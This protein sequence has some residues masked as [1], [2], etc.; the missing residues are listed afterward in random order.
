M[1]Y[2]NYFTYIWLSSSQC[3]IRSYFC[4]QVL[5]V[6]DI[7]EPGLNRERSLILKELAG[8]KKLILQRKLLKQEISEDEFSFQI[9]E[10]VKLFNEYQEGI[11]VRLRKDEKSKSLAAAD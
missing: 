9:Q 8:T 1:W 7:I 6:L 4:F 5:N 10:C 11:V 3:I 2:R